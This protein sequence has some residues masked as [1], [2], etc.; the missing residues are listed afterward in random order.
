[1]KLKERI[2]INVSFWLMLCFAYLWVAS[3]TGEIETSMTIT[4]L[5]LM[6]GTPMINSDLFTKKDN[7]DN[8]TG[9]PQGEVG[10]PSHKSSAKTRGTTDQIKDNGEEDEGEKDGS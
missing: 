6:L 9:L 3:R 5:I 8:H 10:I 4:L 7:Q 2:I 1:M